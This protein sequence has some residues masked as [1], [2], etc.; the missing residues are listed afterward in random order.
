MINTVFNTGKQT[1]RQTKR[2]Q[3]HLIM[4]DTKHKDK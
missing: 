4:N 3:Q 1:N 2:Q